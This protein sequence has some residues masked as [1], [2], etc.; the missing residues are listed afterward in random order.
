M[1]VW[2]E[3]L[4]VCR[5]MS[6]FNSTGLA[7]RETRARK[8]NAP[9]AFSPTLAIS[10]FV[11]SNRGGPKKLGEGGG[12]PA[13][14]LSRPACPICTSFTLLY[15][16]YLLCYVSC[17]WCVVCVTTGLRCLTPVLENEKYLVSMA[18]GTLSHAYTMMSDRCAF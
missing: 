2:Q 12:G 11:T 6:S 8:K 14:A 3:L 17:W 15:K 1:V 5:N 13:P 10:N 7:F 18:R 9:R 4:E 16:V